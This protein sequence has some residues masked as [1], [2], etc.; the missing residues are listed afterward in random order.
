MFILCLTVIIVGGIIS[1]WKNL[2]SD[3]GNGRPAGE[4]PGGNFG[5]PP[6]DNGPVRLGGKPKGRRKELANPGGGQTRGN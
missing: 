1:I 3:T 2:F 4:P 5:G 6:P